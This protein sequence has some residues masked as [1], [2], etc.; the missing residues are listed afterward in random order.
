MTGQTH[1]EM[2][3]KLKRTLWNITA[4][5]CVGLGA[6]GVVVPGMPTTIFL[7]IALYGFTVGG[8]EKARQ[9]LLN[10]PRFGEGLRRWEETKS[11]PLGVKWIA[12]LSIL[13]M[14]TISIFVV[15]SWWVRGIIALVAAIGV[16]YIVSRPTSFK[17]RAAV[18]HTPI[19][20]PE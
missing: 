9:K 8:N 19:G 18:R 1:V 7:I 13:I 16:W 2:P 5:S 20:L 11:I 14:S 12:C 6:V 17:D 10:H 3:G 4:V 15:P